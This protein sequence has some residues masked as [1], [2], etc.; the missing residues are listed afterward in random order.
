MAS[1]VVCPGFIATE[2]TPPFFIAFLPVA[3][4]VRGVTEAFHI[5]VQV[6]AHTCIAAALA[7]RGGGA[8]GEPL[9]ADRKYALRVGRLVPVVHGAPPAPLEAQERM[10]DLCQRWLKIWRESERG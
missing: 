6:G 1:I 4:L 10:W 3:R 5:D 7:L 8:S 2:L 9:Q